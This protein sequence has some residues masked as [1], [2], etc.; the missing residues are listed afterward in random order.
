MAI[1]NNVPL[2]KLARFFGGICESLIIE[3]VPKG[4]PKVEMLLASR[5]DIFTDYTREAF[6]CEF[7]SIFDIR[8]TKDISGSK[9]TLYL[10]KVRSAKA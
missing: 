3:F 9:R 4:D 10:M 7:T 2:R 8:E 1:S 5:K 6:E